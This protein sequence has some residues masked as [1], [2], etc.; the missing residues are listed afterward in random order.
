[1][2]SS[3]WDAEG[4]LVCGGVG[5]VPRTGPGRPYPA[6]HC[7]HRGGGSREPVGSTGRP[8][9]LPRAPAQAHTYFTRAGDRRA[10]DAQTT[11][12]AGR[13]H[14]NQPRDGGSGSC[15][16]GT[17][18]PPRLGAVSFL[19]RPRVSALRANELRRR[20]RRGLHDTALRWRRPPCPA[21]W[22]GA[23]RTTLLCSCWLRSALTWGSRRVAG[24]G[25]NGRT[26]RLKTFPS[27]SNAQRSATLVS[28]RSLNSTAQHG[29]FE[30]GAVSKLRNRSKVG[31]GMV[32]ALGGA[33]QPGHFPSSTS[34]QTG[35]D[36]KGW[37]L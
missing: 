22:P 14:A 26:V 29:T 12:A 34:T 37:W 28:R 13:G 2:G 23:Q 25:P 33:L 18:L 5:R 4:S 10:V 35:S 36:K 6:P 19:L 3:C 32:G 24:E 17:T 30:G 20:A 31:N 1:M 16:L 15:T 11:H 27:L 8:A 9:R 21:L 7:L